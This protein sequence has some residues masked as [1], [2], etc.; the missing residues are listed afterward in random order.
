M[1]EDLIDRRGFLKAGAL[2]SL[3]SLVPAS[4]RAGTTHALAPERALSFYNTHTGESLKAVYWTEG[5]YVSE[6]LNEISHIMRD[7]RT[8]EVLAIDP[9]LLDL[10]H[11]LSIKTGNRRPFHIISGYRSP[12]TNALLRKR[13]RGVAKRSLHVTGQAVDIRLP[14]YKLSALRRA[15]IRL[16]GGGVGYYPRSKFVH[17]D[18]GPVRYW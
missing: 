11:D 5:T 15:A 6:I 12:A 8:D 14:G 9:Q 17:I 16:Q 10:L 7:H 13:N 2:A 18:V 4:L 1:N 3:V